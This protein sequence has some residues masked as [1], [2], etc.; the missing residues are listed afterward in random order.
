MYLF[1]DTE[2]KK[3]PIKPKTAI[4]PD[5]RLKIFLVYENINTSSGNLNNLYPKLS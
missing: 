3:K 2:R 1:V 4:K 5:E